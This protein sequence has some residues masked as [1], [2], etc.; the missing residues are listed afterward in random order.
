[1]SKENKY[2]DP[3]YRKNRKIVLETSNYVCTYCGNPNANTADHVL[4]LEKGGTHDLWNLVSACTSCN[5]TKGD[6][7]R[8][9]LPWANQKYFP[10]GLKWGK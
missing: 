7:D 9:R 8:V 10:G 2:N 1:M 3:L 6:R 4:S 5:S